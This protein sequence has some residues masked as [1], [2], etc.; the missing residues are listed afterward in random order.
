MET[1]ATI[2]FLCRGW[3][4]DI[5][6]VE[7][8]TEGLARTL[9]AA[10]YRVVVLATERDDRRPPHS[11]RDTTVDGIHV[12]RMNRPCAP[13]TRVD[14]LTFDPRAANIVR[15]WVQTVR[16][17]VVHAHHLSGLGL[18]SLEVIDDLHRPLVVSLHDYWSLCPRGQMQDFEGRICPAPAADACARCGTATW[19]HLRADREQTGRRTSRALSLLRR[20]DRLLVPSG[21]AREV[22][23]RAGLERLRISVCENGIE[24]QT[25]RARTQLARADLPRGRRLGVLGSVQP[26]KGVLELAHAV[27]LADVRGLRLAVHGPLEDYHG[28]ASYLNALE[29]LAGQDPRVVLH[30]R[31]EPRDLPRVLATLDAVAVPSRWEEV[32][33]LGAREARAVG[34]PVLAARRG[35]LAL[36]ADDP[37]VTLVEGDELSAWVAALRAFSFARTEPAPVRTLLGMTEQMLGVYRHAWEHRVRAGRVA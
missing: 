26:S 37:G 12:R 36:L 2:G 4:P 14:E 24:S 30:G 35:G 33:G 31:Y 1:A 20:A 25:L 13:V 27:C 3:C 34:L 29:R 17:A 28:D 9:M 6:G 22:F 5:G 10:G 16:P 15:D 8:H 7:T 11:V 23:V 21:A 18:D 19:Q 32:Y